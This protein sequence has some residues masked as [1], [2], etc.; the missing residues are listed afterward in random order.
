MPTNIWD[1]ESLFHMID[2]HL[3]YDPSISSP[4][5]SWTHYLTTAI[6]FAHCDTESRIAVLDTASLRQNV[7]FSHDLWR[8]ALTDR[9]YMNEFLIYG[10]IS[11]PHYHTVSVVDLFKRT[12]AKRILLGDRNAVA[13]E[14]ISAVERGAVEASREMATFLQPL[15]TNLE[16]IVILTARFVGVRIARIRPGRRYLRRGDVHGFLYYIRDDLQTLAI[17]HDAT[18]ISLV[19]PTM[20][21]SYSQGL[22]FEVHLQQAAE[23]AVRVMGWL[24]LP[25][26]S[27]GQWI[28]WVTRMVGD[29]RYRREQ[30]VADRREV[31][32]ADER[33]RDVA[34]TEPDGADAMELDETDNMEVDVVNEM[35]LDGADD[36]QPDVVDEMEL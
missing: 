36:V 24:K 33:E 3:G 15:G 26:T 30:D 2:L 28:D 9:S 12:N 27:R 34:D 35:D 4:F 10:P 18:E 21:T 20:D 6:G 7:F 19:E 1:I 22:K 11:G 8:A 16:N 25:I 17:R 14:R 5:S 32:V 31:N 29:D 23:D 13:R